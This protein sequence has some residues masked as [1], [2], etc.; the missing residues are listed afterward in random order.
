VD[1]N[2]GIGAHMGNLGGP[3]E[4]L[5]A[6]VSYSIA[7]ASARFVPMS[8]ATLLAYATDAARKRRIPAPSSERLLG[9]ALARLARNHWEVAQVMGDDFLLKG[10]GTFALRV[11]ESFGSGKKR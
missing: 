4:A 2:W 7:C 5:I 3:N 1:E 11:G 10:F 9:W 8:R 6:V